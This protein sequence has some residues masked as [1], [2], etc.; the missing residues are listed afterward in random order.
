MRYAA[1][2]ASGLASSIFGMSIV[3]EIIKVGDIR[4][5][6]KFPFY[7]LVANTE[8]YKTD[9]YILNDKY[10]Q[11]ADD[12]IKMVE[13]KGLKPFIVI[14]NKMTLE[15]KKF[16]KESFEVIN[17][18]SK[19][20]DKEL[21][22]LFEAWSKKYIFYYS[23]GIITFIYEIILSERLSESLHKKY[24]NAVELLDKILHSGYTS[25]MIKNEKALLKIKNTKNNNT[26]E[27]LI[28]RY[29]EDYFFMKANYVDAPVMNKATVLAELQNISH[30]ESKYAKIDS[31]RTK[32]TK[33]EKNIA[34][35]LKVSEIIRDQRKRTNLIGSYTMFRF[36]DEVTK[37]RKID[38][39]LAK[40]AFWF[41]F[42]DLVLNTDKILPK[43]KNR[44]MVT[45]IF[46]GKKYLYLEGN[47]I[48]EKHIEKNVAE[49]KGVPASRGIM[50]GK[51]SVILLPNEFSKFRE[52]DILVTEAT[53]PDYV[54]LMKKAS[55]IVTDEGGLTSHAAIV[56][57]E[58][59]KPC[60]VGTK[61]A[62]KVL[63]EGDIVEVDANKGIVKIIRRA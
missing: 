30:K 35:L 29:I 1:D 7:A 23:R 28:S 33:E 2:R 20:S 12:V 62:T 25:F 50:R 43:L 48:E 14:K 9:E 40:R 46:D 53:R 31:K 36:I 61:I 26:K 59:K 22:D 32:L 10:A 44:R 27:K 18:L 47:Q 45:L 17:S 16:K 11:V 15:G 52:G 42:K 39:E 13:K 34:D 4:N 8:N 54:P 49:I 38:R 51:V 21:V 63:K 19:L 60:I 37:R 5:K 6:I 56:A 24:P 58:M 57:R 55:A 41:E 3:L